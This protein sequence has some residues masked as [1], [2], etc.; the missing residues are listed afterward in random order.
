MAPRKNEM[1]TNCKNQRNDIGICHTHQVDK[2]R[3]ADDAG[4]GVEHPHACPT[5]QHVEKH[6]NGQTCRMNQRLICSMEHPIY[7]KARKE[8]DETINQKHDPVRK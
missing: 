5:Q 3:I 6:D 8:Y 7:E 1:E 4:I 2:R